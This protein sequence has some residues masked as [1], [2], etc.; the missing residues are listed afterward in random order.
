MMSD[1]PAVS[2][3]SPA[4]RYLFVLLA[5]LIIGIIATVMLL[6]AWQARQDPFPTALMTVM[7]H[8][9]SQLKA[10][11][12]QNRC[13]QSDS[14]PALQSLR[15]LTNDLDDAFPSLRD[16]TRFQAHA[17]ALRASLNTALSNPPGTCENLTAM[18]RQIDEK[19]QACHQDFK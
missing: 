14:L 9:S 2:A 1:R 16:D 7:S 17:A 12:E 13:N 5:G 6:R 8:Q 19:C 15:A 4:S 3:P 11:R 10:A 18:N